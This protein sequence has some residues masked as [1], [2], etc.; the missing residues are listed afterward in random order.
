M[1]KTRV[2]I[3]GI[4]SYEIAI[5]AIECGVDAL[6]FV[7]Y[8]K[9]PRF[10][11]L[12]DAREI[13]SKLPSLVNKVGVF[14]DKKLEEILRIVEFTGIDT[15]QLHGEY[16]IDFIFKLKENINLPIIYALRREKLS[17]I[18]TPEIKYI[19]N[20]VSN[21]LVDKISNTSYGGTGESLII[22]EVKDR[23]FIKRKVILAGGINISN[24]KEILSKIKPFGID[25]SSGVE[26]EKGKKDIKLI[27]EFFSCFTQYQYL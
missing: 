7:F 14:V 24:I 20:E 1:N 22:D 25:L 16:N 23:D 8:E 2:K 27:E 26:K 9:S 6:G 11:E 12:N 15:I 4:K 3:C 5:K 13:I 19:S 21:I 10:I 17:E 18:E